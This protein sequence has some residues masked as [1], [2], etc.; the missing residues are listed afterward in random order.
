MDHY[1]D[2]LDYLEDH[3][4]VIELR[5]KIYQSTMKDDN[6]PMFGQK[7]QKTTSRDLKSKENQAYRKCL[8][9]IEQTKNQNIELPRMKKL[10][11]VHNLDEFEK[12]VVLTL[13]GSVL[14]VDVMKALGR[15]LFDRT[16]NVTFGQMLGMYTNIK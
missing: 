12:W 5:L 13:L 8:A 11:S 10:I 1:I 3:F 16:G 7:N 15:G 2:N 6:Y 9:R 4:Q 14:S